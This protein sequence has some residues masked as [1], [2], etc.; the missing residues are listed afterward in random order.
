MGHSIHD[1][2][3]NYLDKQFEVNNYRI[4]KTTSKN[5]TQPPLRLK[6][7]SKKKS[8]KNPNKQT[9]ITKKKTI[10]VSSLK[11]NLPPIQTST[12]YKEKIKCNENIIKNDSIINNCNNSDIKQTKQKKTKN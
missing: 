12:K 9:T 8:T 7:D 10:V 1:K 5:K 11:G 6:S 2:V 3:S 4:I